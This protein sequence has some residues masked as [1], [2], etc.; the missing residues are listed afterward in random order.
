MPF[1]IVG[2]VCDSSTRSE[3]VAD[4][5]TV[6][7]TPFELA[8]DSTTRQALTA[9]LVTFLCA[10]MPRRFRA[11]PGGRI[12]CGLFCSCRVLRIL[13]NLGCFKF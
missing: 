2:L 12:S 8:K 11:V 9:P 5:T 13:L 1:G 7:V 3:D 10:V 4:A 6:G